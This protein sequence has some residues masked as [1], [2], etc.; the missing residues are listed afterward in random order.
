MNDILQQA[1]NQ[2]AKPELN[3]KQ[4]RAAFKQQVRRDVSAANC[5]RSKYKFRHKVE[6]RVARVVSGRILI[7]NLML[8]VL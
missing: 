8:R 1:M 4:R 2:Q 3:R 5:P 7:E 6:R